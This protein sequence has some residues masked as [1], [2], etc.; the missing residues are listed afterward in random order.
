MEEYNNKYS[1]QLIDIE[2]VNLL[3][4]DKESLT[5]FERKEAEVELLKLEEAFKS[6][7]VNTLDLGGGPPTGSNN[8]SFFKFF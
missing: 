3:L 6:E 2:K 1:K 8:I 5:D 7:E 4:E